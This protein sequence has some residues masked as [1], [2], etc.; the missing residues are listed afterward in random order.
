MTQTYTG[1]CHCQQIQFRAQLN[2][3]Q[4]MT[5]NCS[6]CR[7]SGHILAFVGE[8][9][10]ELLQGEDSLQDYQFNKKVIHHLFCKTC[11]IRA[12]GRGVGADG[13]KMVAVN[14]RCLDGVDP[15]QL[16]PMFYD[17]KSL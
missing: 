2:M 15:E 3:E 10:F 5:C 17:G 8:E 11:G 7:R 4:V 6:I 16:K 9:G 14:V 1:S 13:K 12:F